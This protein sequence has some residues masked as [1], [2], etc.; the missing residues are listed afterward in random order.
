[1]NLVSF[2]FLFPRFFL[3]KLLLLLLGDGAA[4]KEKKTQVKS[5]PSPTLKI[6]KHFG[7]LLSKFADLTPSKKYSNFL[8]FYSTESQKFILVFC[9]IKNF[10]LFLIVF[11]YF[12]GK[13]KEILYFY[14][15]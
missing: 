11:F 6:P 5:A 10:A 13:S 15:F 2:D 14:V 8:Y 4:P 12:F 1:M 3:P 7:H 9:F